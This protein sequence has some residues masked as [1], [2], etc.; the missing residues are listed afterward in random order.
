[1]GALLTSRHSADRSKCPHSNIGRNSAGIY[2]GRAKSRGVAAARARSAVPG[3]RKAVRR[4]LLDGG[5]ALVVVLRARPREKLSVLSL[6]PLLP[7]SG[8][9]GGPEQARRDVPGLGGTTLSLPLLGAEA[10]CPQACSERRARASPARSRSPR[11]AC[12]SAIAPSRST[13]D[14]S[15]SPALSARPRSSAASAARGSPRCAHGAPLTCD[16]RADLFHATGCAASC[17]MRQ[18]KQNGVWRMAVQGRLC[19]F[20]YK[21]INRSGRG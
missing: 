17:A 3:R 5:D 9:V 21:Q 16:S 14:S 19:L 15:A 4:L 20:R 10:R 18:C 6:V 8:R 7:T 1:M 11:S 12:A 2:C 13:G